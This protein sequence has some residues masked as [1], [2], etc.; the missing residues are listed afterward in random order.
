MKKTFLLFLLLFSFST[1]SQNQSKQ[2]EF[3]YAD[4]K[5]AGTLKNSFKNLIYEI[6]VKIDNQGVEKF[7]IEKMNNITIGNESYVSSFNN[8]DK[9]LTSDPT[10]FTNDK[11]PNFKKEWLLL[12][13][14]VQGDYNLYSYEQANFTQFYFSTPTLKQIEPLIYKE[15]LINHRTT[16]ANNQFQNQL[17]K[18][19]QLPE[20]GF[21]DYKKIEYK[22]SKLIKYFNKLN[23][24]D[25]EKGI[26]KTKLNVSVFGGISM[27]KFK[28]DKIGKDTPFESML[29]VIGIQGLDKLK[30]YQSYNSPTIGAA[31]E[32][33]FSHKN[34]SAVFT[35]V[36]FSIF[37]QKIYLE[38][39]QMGDKNINYELKSSVLLFNVG[40]KHYFDLSKNMQV[41]SQGAISIITYINGKNHATWE[42]KFGQFSDNGFKTSTNFGGN[43]GLGLKL[44]KHYFI[45]ANFRESLNSGNST[46]TFT[47]GYTF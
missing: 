35:N 7:L 37:N 4:K 17:Y 10:N 24:F 5:I 28:S 14:L 16:I 25:L 30:S 43:L 6:E 45:E 19:A 29:Y 44:N 42:N 40:Y 31:L 33:P 11:K 39:N 21:L 38:D 20:L 23:N 13:V 47:L 2:I 36:S 46:T 34:I 8:I 3:T 32:I 22:K 1:F 15:Y 9:S 12:K 18:D 41:Y 27:N 26:S